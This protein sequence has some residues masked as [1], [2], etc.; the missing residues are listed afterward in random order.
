MCFALFKPCLSRISPAA[1]LAPGW[2]GFV[3]PLGRLPGSTDTWAAL[4]VRGQGEGFPLEG[5]S[6]HLKRCSESRCGEIHP[7]KSVEMGLRVS[8][9]G[10]NGHLQS[11]SKAGLFIRGLLIRLHQLM[12]SRFTH[13]KTASESHPQV[14][15]PRSHSR[16]GTDYR[17]LKTVNEGFSWIHMLPLFHD[18][19]RVAPQLLKWIE[20]WV[21]KTLEPN[22]SG[23]ES[24]PCYI[25][26]VRKLLSCP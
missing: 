19:P 22:K 5:L 17:T 3:P 11:C 4:V 16:L 10:K 20:F 9:R 14:T 13:H 6:L 21:E 2:F 25:L 15:Y 18:F 23:L 24:C 1:N 7:W 26:N 8:G 12:T